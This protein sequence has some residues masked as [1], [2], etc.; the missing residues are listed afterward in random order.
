M[1]A[2]MPLSV[3]DVN[4]HIIGFLKSHLELKTEELLRVI[5]EDLPLTFVA[6]FCIVDSSPLHR[7]KIFR[8]FFVC[9]FDRFLRDLQSIL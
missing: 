2:Q 3:S 5:A 9:L 8:L 6:D 4:L 7:R 1:P